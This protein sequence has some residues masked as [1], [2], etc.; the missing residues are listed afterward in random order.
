M[1]LKQVLLINSFIGSIFEA[2]L[3][4]IIPNITP[5]KTDIDAEPIRVLQ[6]IQP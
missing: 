2:F 1:N 3:A 5:T 6:L 4:G